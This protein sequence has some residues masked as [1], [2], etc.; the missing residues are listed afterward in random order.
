MDPEKAPIFSPSDWMWLIEMAIGLVVIVLLSI[1]FKKA[2]TLI[3]KKTAHKGKGWKRTIDKIV[4]TPLQ[5]ALW[6]F[7]IAYVIDIASTHFGLE[8]VTKYIRPTKTAFVVACFGWIIL[9]WIKEAFKH[10]ARKSEKLGI[11]PGTVYTMNKLV[12][13][14]FSI[15]MGLI[16]FQIFGM[17]IGPLLAIGGIGVAGLAYAGKDIFANFFGGAMLHFTRTFSIGDEIV[18]PSKNNFEGEVRDIGW[19][20]TMVEDYYRRPVY[21]PNALFS[22]EQVINESRRSHR[23]IKETFSIRY[24]DS[25]NL[26][27]IIDEVKQKVGAHPDVDNTQS[28]SITFSKFGDYGLDFFMYLLV[29]K[30]GYIKF[31]RVKQEILFIVQ[32]VVQKYGAEFCYP[33]TNVNLIQTPPTLPR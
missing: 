2:A 19:Y 12:S 25:P 9:R 29:H 11:A 20:T 3:H 22:H 5:I 30:M 7:G 24:D 21:F 28:F 15:L 8:V 6:G 26:E 4:H 17:N 13:F 32:D 23:R 16:I 33:T 10:L 27:K 1:V 18:I 31:L 14:V